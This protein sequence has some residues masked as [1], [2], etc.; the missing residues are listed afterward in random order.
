M[1]DRNLEYLLYQTLVGAWPISAER[2]VTYMEKAVREAKVHTSW[3]APVPEYEHA[4]L[5]F[6][7]AVVGD[8][9]FVADL[10]EFLAPVV[11]AGWRTSLAMKLVCLT[12]PGVPD[13]Y[14]GSELWDLSLVDPDNRRPVDFE[15]RRRLLAELDA[16]GERAAAVAWERRA[17]GLPKL[18]V[19]SRALRMRAE[20][21]DVFACGDY[22]PLR[23]AGARAANAIAFCRGDAAVTVVPRLAAALDGWADASVELPAGRFV[24]RFTGREVAGGSVPLD[25]LLGGFPVA[26]LLRAG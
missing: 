12:A 25:V 19:V 22:R 5:R 26:L 1:P 7:E 15:L 20:L 14:Q 23:V 18:L 2:L 4:V 9:A 10:E 13:V 6:A 8:A 16:L 21:P 11:E 24:D 3:L 17:E